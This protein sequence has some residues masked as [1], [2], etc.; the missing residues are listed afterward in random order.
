MDRLLQ[1]HAR[2]TVSDYQTAMRAWQAG[3]NAPGE[4]MPESFRIRPLLRR[5]PEHVAALDRIRE[6]T[7]ARFKLPD[8]AAVMAAEV[9]C[10]LPGCPPLETVVAFWTETDR[11]H[12]FKIFK[13]AE[14]VAADDLPPAFMKTAL[15]VDEEAG[16][17]CC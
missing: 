10:A 5:S 15:M 6:W 17:E 16:F 11:R 13:R 9:A 4:G 8:D 1:V 3:R 2:P 12:Q 7:R 14:E